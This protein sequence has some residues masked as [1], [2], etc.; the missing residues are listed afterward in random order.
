MRLIALLLLIGPGFFAWFVEG[1]TELENW[2]D[3]VKAIAKWVVNSY[4][5]M[6]VMYFALNLFYGDKQVSFSAD[7]NDD[8]WNS[9]FQISFVAKYSAITACL[10]AALGLLERKVFPWIKAGFKRR[11]PNGKR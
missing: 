4:L 10:S 5:I 11:L 3:V 6:A 7:R 8:M 1:D 9:I 2:R